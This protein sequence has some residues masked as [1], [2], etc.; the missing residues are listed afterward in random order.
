MNKSVDCHEIADHIYSP[1]FINN[2]MQLL[3][4]ILC[5]DKYFW[6]SEF[7]LWIFKIG[8]SCQKPGE[9]REHD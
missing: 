7:G 5:A 1:Y 8:R 6:K 9:N 4:A 3:I 2:Q